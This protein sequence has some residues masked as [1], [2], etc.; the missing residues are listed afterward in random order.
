[1]TLLIFGYR[2]L[3]IV[4]F[5]TCK[6]MLIFK[7]VLSLTVKNVCKWSLRKPHK[8]ANGVKTNNTLQ[9]HSFVVWES[10]HICNK[11]QQWACVS[12]A[13]EVPYEH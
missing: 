12:F 13:K 11:L 5:L 9:F 10:V 1:M 4:L 3:S 7:G 2:S 6:T 8:K